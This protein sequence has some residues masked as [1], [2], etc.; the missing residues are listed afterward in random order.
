MGILEAR[1]IEETIYIMHLKAAI[2]I[3]IVRHGCQT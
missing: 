3:N 2:L 1:L